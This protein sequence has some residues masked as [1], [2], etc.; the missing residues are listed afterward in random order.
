MKA[1]AHSNAIKT[2]YIKTN[3]QKVKEYLVKPI[4]AGF[5]GFATILM[6][7]FFINLLSFIFGTVE[8]FGMDLL[9]MMLA[10]VGFILQL[11]GTLLK[12]FAR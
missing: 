1:I 7:L 5:L 12:S 4:K 10:A 8:H 6:V 11:S 9:D 2:N 3:R